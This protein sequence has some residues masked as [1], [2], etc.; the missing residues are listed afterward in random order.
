MKNARSIRQLLVGGAILLS[1]GMTLILGTRSV[2]ARTAAQSNLTDVTS[3][4]VKGHTVIA[5]DARNRNGEF[6]AEVTV[7][8]Y[9]L[10]PNTTYQLWRAIDLVPDGVFDPAAPGFP[11]VEI[12]TITTSSGGAGAA[13][14][15][16]GGGLF[17]GDMF[18]VVI[19]V[20]QDDG[21]TVALESDVM[22]ITV[23]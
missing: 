8:I 18:D 23:K 4:E 15:V 13:N 6:H 14:F 5:P 17:S 16:R 11:F 1:F 20:R 22:T 3:G 19:Q 9:N 12:A 7:V 2:A 10:E 21:A